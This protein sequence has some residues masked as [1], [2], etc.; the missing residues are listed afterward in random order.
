MERSELRARPDPGRG[1][2]PSAEKVSREQ[3]LQAWKRE[4]DE[5]VGSIFSSLPIDWPVVSGA[6]KKAAIEDVM[7]TVWALIDAPDGA[8][9]ANREA[10]RVHLGAGRQGGGRKMGAWP[11]GGTARRPASSQSTR[12][13]RPPASRVERNRPMSARGI[14]PRSTR[15]CVP[16]GMDGRPRPPGRGHAAP[17]KILLLRASRAAP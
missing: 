12:P 14:F 5:C 15:I 8:L 16:R 2:S 17:G 6:L 4:S 10:I 13:P 1:G 7:R 11:K 9:W 3:F